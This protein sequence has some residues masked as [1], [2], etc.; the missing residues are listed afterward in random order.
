MQWNFLVDWCITAT[1]FLLKATRSN[2]PKSWYEFKSWDHPLSNHTLIH[3][4][5]HLPSS[6]PP[7]SSSASSSSFH[8][9]T[10]R[11]MVT[12]FSSCCKRPRRS[13][14]FTSSHLGQTMHLQW[15]TLLLGPNGEGFKS[16]WCMC[17]IYCVLGFCLDNY[18]PCDVCVR[19]CLDIPIFCCIATFCMT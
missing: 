1:T 7:P 14:R 15:R 17:V 12:R 9:S 16:A 13:P 19:L 4:S 6:S 5:T 18:A 10:H 8:W 2:C 11:K 3:S